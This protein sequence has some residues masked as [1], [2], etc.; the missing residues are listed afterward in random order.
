MKLWHAVRRLGPVLELIDGTY[1]K[2]SHDADQRR[3]WHLAMA[4]MRAYTAKYA[5]EDFEVVALERVFEG[6]IVNPATRK[7]SRSFMLKGKVDGIV[8]RGDEYFLLEHKTAS[9]MG[10]DYLKRL[11]T[12]FQITLYAHYVEQS[13][14]AFQS[15]R[16]ISGI[17]Y[18][19]LVKAKLQQSRGE[20]EA[21][22]EERR[23]ALRAKDKGQRTEKNGRLPLFLNRGEPPLILRSSSFV[24]RGA[25]RARPC[26]FFALCRSNGNPNVVENFYRRAPAHEE[27]R[28]ETDTPPEAV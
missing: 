10:A 27:L 9:Q 11:W 18:N 14:A 24:L 19:I 2:R 26:P 20:T 5:T 23:S 15:V 28:A 22:F 8:K 3:E 7:P 21:E 17:V 16:R 13:L 4:M 25:S 6:E 12:D 1:P